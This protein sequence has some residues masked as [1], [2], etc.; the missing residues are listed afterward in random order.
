MPRS[1]AEY[2]RQFALT[3][4][5]VNNEIFGEVKELIQRY[6]KEALKVDYFE[7]LRASIVDGRPGLITLWPVEGFLSNSIRDTGG[8]YNGQTAYVFDKGVS[9]W[10]VNKDK[11]PLAST[12]NYV[13]LWHDRN[14]LPGYVTPGSVREPIRTTI[15]IPLRDDS[16]RVFGVLDFEST[17]YLGI[18]EAAKR[19]L[20]MIAESLSI[21][22]SLERTNYTQRVST[23]SAV[24]ELEKTLKSKRLPRLSKPVLFLAFSYKADT[25]VIGL[26]RE[27]LDDYEDHLEVIVWD[28]VSKSGN[29][30]N[31]I[32][33][34]ILCSRYGICYFSEPAENSVNKYQDNPNVL[35][36]AGMLHALYHTDADA[37]DGWIPMREP[38][39][40]PLPF[41]FIT[42]RMLKVPRQSDGEL[43]EH[44]FKSDLRARIRSLIN[45]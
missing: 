36:E 27:V 40:P 11:S 34:D 38:D 21:L 6:V 14:D 45:S 12:S 44:Q 43:N 29:I 23:R 22:Y 10:V 25:S 4:D 15:M 39:S 19:E 37:S 13:D 3:V 5:I 26:I 1:F 35:I 18:T 2:L 31:Q 30:S 20:G 16:G 24:H 32:I 33:D 7:F 9:L 41:D 28:R 8:N 17:R 42:E